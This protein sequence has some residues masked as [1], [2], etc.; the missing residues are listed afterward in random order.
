MREAGEVGIGPDEGVAIAYPVLPE[1]RV[2]VAKEKFLSILD[3]EEC[4][5]MVA[6]WLD[7]E[8]NIHKEKNQKA[9]QPMKQFGF[10][11]RR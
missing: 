3:E 6:D 5:I 1:S 11:Q 10:Q 2:L 8:Y 7:L 9:K 4:E